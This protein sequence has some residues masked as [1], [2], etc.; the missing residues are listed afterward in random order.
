MMKKLRVALLSIL[1]SISGLPTLSAQDERVVTEADM[2]RIAHTD[3]RDAL[4]TFKVADGFQLE[5]VAAE[6]LVSDP[7]AA[8]FDEYGRMFV[9]EMHGYPFSQEP[10]QL[11]PEGGGLK[12][13]GI[14][15]MLEDTDGDGTMD[16]STVYADKLSWPTSVVPYNGGIFVMA[17]KYLYYLKDT[18]GDNKADVRE[19]LLEG[20]GRN[21]VQSVANGLIWGLDNRIYFAAGRNPKNL[22]HRGEPLFPVSGVDLRF[23]PRT[24]SFETV[25]GGVQFGHSRDIWG[26]RFVCSNSN[27]IQQVIHPQHYITRNPY[28]VASGMIRSIASDGASARV[29]RLSP[30]EPWRIVRQKWRALDKGY[31]LVIND[32]GGWEFIPLD[33]S[34]PSGVVPTEYPVGFFTSA[35]GITIYSGDAYPKRY[36]GNAFVG[37]VGG[38]L[39]HRKTVDSAGVVY[40][41]KR[42][43]EGVEFIQSTDNW[44]RP[45]NFLNAPDGTIYVLDMYRETVEHPYSIPAEI[46]KFLHLT[47]GKDRGRIYRVV[48][49]DMKVRA[50]ANL[51][52]MS[53]SEL[54]SELSSNNGWNRD[55]AQ[56]LLV[57][58]QDD[59]VRLALDELVFNGNTSLGRLHGLYTLHGLNLLAPA[60]LFAGLLDPEPRVKAHAIKLA[61]PFLDEHANLVDQIKTLTSHTSEHVRVQMA[62]S[63]GAAKPDMAV[64][65]LAELGLAS[66]STPE[67]KTAVL[68]SVGA[69]SDRFLLQL[70]KTGKN[71]PQLASFAIQTAILVGSNPNDGATFNV[72]SKTS[73]LSANLQTII[74]RGLG[75]GLSRRG[76]TLRAMILSPAAPAE[77][78]TQLGD[79]FNASVKQVL[80]PKVELPSRLATMQL[81]A[82]S[83]LPSTTDSLA[84]LL[85]PQ[86][87]QSLQLQ[88]V[89]T[90]G[91]IN[92][93]Q[94][95]SILLSRWKGFSPL[96]RREVVDV[97]TRTTANSHQLLDAIAR[98][99]IQ[100]VE[101]ERDKIQILLQHPNKDL[102][103]KS[104]SLFGSEANSDR[105]KVVLQFQNVLN[106]EGRV[107]AGKEVFT[108]KC[109]I[110]H[111][112]GDIG[113]QVAPNLA[114]VKN[115]SEAD[116]LIAIL[117]PNREAQPNFNVY[118]VLTQQGRVLT[119]IIA[120]ETATSLTLKR[121]EGKQDVVLRSNIDELISNGVSLMPEGLEKE[122]N[123]QDIAD[124]ISFIKQS[125]DIK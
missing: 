70:L 111:Q 6:P 101:I 83:H 93:P 3:P 20:F 9:A 40:S 88:V 75:E 122:L 98:K 14:I 41:S 8:C 34:K 60:H 11:N 105:A 1:A 68:S 110:C 4:S 61:E 65:T 43:D 104:H 118:T 44:F 35:T 77:L 112:A 78:S 47:S 27:H 38:N 123:A 107:A 92:A 67:I 58:R 25:T 59:S 96:V 24:E 29:F 79:L 84:T 18:N 55:T 15:R 71:Q 85:D 19:V 49:K 45:V 72:L 114:S 13:A 91:A 26:T 54:V 22:T 30:P 62:Y 100:R 12:D 124:V 116:L 121:A 82:F 48:R 46:K 16:R 94:L 119:G 115:K 63:L 108:K 37:D 90:L 7:V 80:D 97:L 33:P 74:L 73:N 66:N 86:T 76:K 125:K 103:A 113:T 57:E 51:G 39:V 95:A 23:D 17:P 102:Q 120:S 56:R 28:L 87:P 50:P 106:L 99:K 69:Y 2:P 53:N 5:L 52:G 89:Q 36:L 109:S 117:D 42:A 32:D 81:L 10:T 21:N 31:R 64:T